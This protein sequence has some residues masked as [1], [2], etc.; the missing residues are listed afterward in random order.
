MSPIDRSGTVQLALPKGRIQEGVFELFADAGIRI[1]LGARG[2]RPNLSIPGFEAK[3]LKPQNVVEMLGGGLRDV[4]FAGVDWVVE[5]G[6]ELV[7]LLDTELDPVRLVAA[8]PA[9]LL[10]SGGLPEGPLVVASEYERLTRQWMTRRGIE[11]SFVRTYGATEV[12]PPEDAD[13]IVDN[14][15]TGDTLAANGLEIFDEVLQSST[16]MFANSKALDDPDKRRVI[17]DLTLVLRSVIEARSRAMVELNVDSERLETVIQ[18]LPT[19]REATVSRLH[20]DGGY[21]IRAAVPRSQLVLLI[22][23]LRERGASDI[24]ITRPDQIVP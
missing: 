16:R 19:M 10:L 3:L 2:Y 4:G 17:E 21:A 15:A 22:P 9:D 12:F 8:A 13:V 14:T 20:G 18:S 5:K 1:R 6:A 7:E 11:G 24:V 23:E